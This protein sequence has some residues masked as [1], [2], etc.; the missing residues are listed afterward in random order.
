MDIHKLRIFA[1]SWNVAYRKKKDSGL[2]DRL[3]E[4]FTVIEN[5]F[6][7]WAAD[8]FLYEKDNDVYIFAELYDYIHARG[9]IGYYQLTA[10]HPRWVPIIQESHHL[11]FP[12]IYE[13]NG[14]V[15]IMPEAHKSNTLY[16]YRAESFPDRWVK[17][18][19]FLTDICLVDTTPIREYGYNR[20]LAYD[21]SKDLLKFIDLETKEIKLLYNDSDGLKRP[22]GYINAAAGIRAAQECGNDYGKGIIFYQFELTQ[23]QDY[24]E[25]ELK[26]VHPQD[27]ILSREVYL[28]GMHTYNQSNHY[29]VIDIKTRRFNVLNICMRMIHNIS[30]LLKKSMYCVISI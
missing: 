26:R 8:P 5:S 17:D 3:D 23:E 14:S 6:R 18:A 13:M 19:V 30:K 15:Y 22:A 20:A 11:S 25:L 10:A 21:S 27:V 4:P 16:R 12:F 1:E 24:K 7:Y 2:L 9:V 28:D 29:E